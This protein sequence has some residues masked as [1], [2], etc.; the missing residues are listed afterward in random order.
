MWNWFY[1]PMW[2]LVC[3]LLVERA[4]IELAYVLIPNQET[5]LESDARELEIRIGI[6]PMTSSFARSRSFPLSYRIMTIVYPPNH[7]GEPSRTRTCGFHVRS[8]ALY[9]TELSVRFTAKARA[10]VGL[11]FAV[12]AASN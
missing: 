8:M 5:L 11:G 6:E 1:N 4:R 12:C 2:E 3:S 7:Y 9:S 10:S